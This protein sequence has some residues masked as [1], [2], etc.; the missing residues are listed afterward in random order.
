MIETET[1]VAEVEEARGKIML[2]QQIHNQYME[3][4]WG[5]VHGGT[6]QLKKSRKPVG[7]KLGT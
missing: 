2:E 3:E 5:D 7:K 1:W 4:A 6:C